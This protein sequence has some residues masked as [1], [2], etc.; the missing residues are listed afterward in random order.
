MSDFPHTFDSPIVQ[1]SVGTYAYTVVFLP[2]EM[3]EEMPFDQFPRLRV[4]GE[5]NH[6][7]FAGAFQPVR[8]RWYLLLSKKKMKA[9]GF[10]IGD[11]V[12]VTF[13]IDDQ[14]AVEVP[15]ML[16]L[17]LEEN[18]HAMATWEK[19]SAGKRRGLAY[20][21]SSAKTAPTQ[22]RRVAVVIEML[23]LGTV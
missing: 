7:P 6:L 12:H 20:R 2:E 5:I 10:V 16:R 9:G 1:H 22:K 17:A 23:V 4:R 19:L 11:W 21:V 18:P 13:R 3:N 15:D 14:E 8:G